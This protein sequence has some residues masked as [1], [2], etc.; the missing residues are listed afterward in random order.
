MEQKLSDAQR[1]V[2]KWLGCGWESVPGAGMSIHVNDKRV[3]NCDTLFA[4]E[5]MGLVEQKTLGGRRLVGQWRAT[6]AGRAL[7]GKM[8]L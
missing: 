1:R 5:R 4:L 8:C 3:C 2:M 7:A 6:E